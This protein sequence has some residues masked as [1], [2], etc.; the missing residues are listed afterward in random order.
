[1]KKL[2]LTA[3]LASANFAHAYYTVGLE[4]I[5]CQ[6]PNLGAVK[7]IFIESG[8]YY[9]HGANPVAS[10]PGVVD[11]KLGTLSL[12]GA[13]GVIEKVNPSVGTSGLFNEYNFPS[14]FSYTNDSRETQV[15]KFET[16]QLGSV[17]IAYRCNMQNAFECEIRGGS[18]VT[19]AR[20]KVNLN[21][22]RILSFDGR[23]LP[24]CKRNIRKV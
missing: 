14:Y 22:K 15:L 12:L 3:I 4:Q 1:M 16:K 10:I 5:V 21:G 24:M 17:F 8:P 23:T 18:M 2:I 13:N 11:D 9:A 6:L 19:T 7:A 20:V